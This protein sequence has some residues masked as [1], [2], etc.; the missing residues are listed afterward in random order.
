MEK[1]KLTIK[2]I[3]LPRLLLMLGAGIVLL[4]LSFP[5]SRS[6][7]NTAGDG[8]DS[9]PAVS[10][11]ENGAAWPDDESA[12]DAAGALEQ[13]LQELLK[14]V[15]GIGDVQ[16][17]ITLK[18][19]AETVVLKDS[20]YTSEITEES[21]SEG[22]HRTVTQIEQGEETILAND[23]DPYVIKRIEPEVQGVVVIAEGAGDLRIVTE[24]VEAVEVL[25]EVPAHK[26]KV[27]KMGN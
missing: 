15:S 8:T 9:A 5:D 1:K 26:V 23:N 24:I 16:V 21:D 20:P 4:M 11:R 7:E 14:K 18:S 12:A 13:R 6:G 25:F 3:G 2:E 27:M 19:S 17:M 22:G 10:G